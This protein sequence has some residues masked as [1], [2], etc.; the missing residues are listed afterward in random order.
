MSG[1][2]HFIGFQGLLRAEDM[3]ETDVGFSFLSLCASVSCVLSLLPETSF[4]FFLLYCLG[5][6]MRAHQLSGTKKTNDHLTTASKLTARHF[7]YLLISGG[8]ELDGAR[9]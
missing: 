1:S 9:R 5:E 8:R 7:F 2:H 4:I 6:W 3:K